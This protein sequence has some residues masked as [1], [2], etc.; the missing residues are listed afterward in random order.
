MRTGWLPEHRAVNGAVLAMAMT[1][2][3]V[4]VRRIRR[5][6]RMG[7]DKGR[8]PRIGRRKAR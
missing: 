5:A 1:L 8:E 6:V 7:L 4:R 3:T 2:T